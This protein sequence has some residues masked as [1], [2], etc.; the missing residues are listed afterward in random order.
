IFNGEIYNFR[1]LRRELE[2]ASER[3]RSRSDTEVLLAAIARWGVEASLG[4]TIGMFAFALWDRQAR[5]LTLARD[6][7]GKKPL[8]VGVAGGDVVCGSELKARR[9]PP[10]FD[11]TIDRG[12][13]SLFL[14]HGYVPAP[15][16]ISQ[17]VGKL[18][19]GTTLA[20]DLGLLPP[21]PSPA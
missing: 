2:A 18:R 4:R 17:A 7:R 14:R 21:L 11:A 13:L 9:A 1:D 6:R 19:P 5:R 3:F 15:Y 8:S 10:S 16:S 20:L 12:A